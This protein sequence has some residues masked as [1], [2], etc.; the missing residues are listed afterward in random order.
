MPVDTVIAR[1]RARST[2]ATISAQRVGPGSWL[3]QE[4]GWATVCEMHSTCVM[5]ETRRLAKAFMAAPEEWC[6]PC[7]QI[8]TSAPDSATTAPDAP[9]PA[10][11]PPAPAPTVRV[12]VSRPVLDY[13][14]GTGLWQ[15]R[16]DPTY[17]YS[18]VPERDAAAAL[19]RDTIE[20]APRRA[21]GSVRVALPEAV[22]RELYEYADYLRDLAH[23]S[24]GYDAYARGEYNAAGALMRQLAELAPQVVAAHRARW[25]AIGSA[26]NR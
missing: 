9:A 19:L 20:A 10:A 1:R 13:L 23:D 5:H 16:N 18:G 21:D 3:E 7:E 2:G 15:Q 4:P 17:M 26:Y 12:R 24:A 8:A 11:T 22:L 6:Q 14:D 25:A